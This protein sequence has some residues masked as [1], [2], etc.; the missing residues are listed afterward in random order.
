MEGYEYESKQTP[1]EKEILVNIFNNALRVRNTLGPPPI[2]NLFLS[3]FTPASKE[4]SKYRNLVQTY[5]SCLP[6]SIFYYEKKPEQLTLFYTDGRILTIERNTKGKIKAEQKHAPNHNPYP[7]Q[8]LHIINANLEKMADMLVNPNM[9]NQPS[10]LHLYWQT[11]KN[12]QRG[13]PDFDL[14][15]WGDDI[16]RRWDEIKNTANQYKDSLPFSDIQANAGIIHAYK[17]KD[18]V[19]FILEADKDEENTHT[20]IVS[21]KK[22]MF[23]DRLSIHI[24]GPFIPIDIFTRLQDALSA[25]QTDIMANIP[26]KNKQNDA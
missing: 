7:I 26:K 14:Y 15:K 12:S 21:I 10:N 2:L 22:E 8:V 20:V 9:Q 1:Q 18:G 24:K 19:I 25:V 17:D 5:P 3:P 16:I 6:L 13:E 23:R 4:A 11:E